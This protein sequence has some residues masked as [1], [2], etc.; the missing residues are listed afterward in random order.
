MTNPH[1]HTNVS[2]LYNPTGHCL[3]HIP[4]DR[5][6]SLKQNYDHFK[7]HHPTKWNQLTQGG[8]YHTDLAALF[9]RYRAAPAATNTLSPLLYQAAAALGITHHRTSN[10]LSY[11][12]GLTSFS[13]TSPADQLFGS[14][15]DPFLTIWTGGSLVDIPNSTTQAHQALRWALASADH[16]ENIL[17]PTCTLM[18]LPD[19][20]AAPYKTLLH[21]SWI[22]YIDSRPQSEFYITSK[23]WLGSKL[24]LHPPP[25]NCTS[26]LYATPTAK[27]PTFLNSKILLTNGHTTCKASPHLGSPPL[28]HHLPLLP[29]LTL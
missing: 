4:N 6:T 9:T 16:A 17:S 10:P 18:L 14:N 3:G 26:S 15:Q 29:P 28:S 23:I 1:T 2:Y 22:H 20:L 25:Q 21:H 19:D 5:L 7:N 11:D 27:I 8:T 12:Q 13:S 24:T